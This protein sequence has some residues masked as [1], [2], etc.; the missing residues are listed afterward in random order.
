M[1]PASGTDRAYPAAEPHATK[2]KV[3]LESRRLKGES[4]AQVAADYGT[5]QQ[6][7]SVLSSWHQQ[8]SEPQQMRSLAALLL[9]ATA[10]AANNPPPEAPA[11]EKTATI[12]TPCDCDLGCIFPVRNTDRGYE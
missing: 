4:Q 9:V 6:C 10:A 3:H 5:S 8:P 12:T 2:T 11:V 7:I 1:S